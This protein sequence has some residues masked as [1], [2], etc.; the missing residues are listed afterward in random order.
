M[1]SS[2]QPNLLALNALITHDP[3]TTEPHYFRVLDHLKILSDQNRLFPDLRREVM[4]KF[5][6]FAADTSSKYSYP[7]S[8][9]SALANI[10]RK[11]A[12]LTQR[13][14]VLA[15]AEI[16]KLEA[17]LVMHV[18][19]P[20]ATRSRHRL[21]L[22]KL[23]DSRR[24]V[25]E[26]WILSL[27]PLSYNTIDREVRAW[28]DSPIDWDEVEYFRY[29]WEDF[30]YAPKAAKA[31]FDQF[32]P[33]VLEF[34]GIKLGDFTIIESNKPLALYQMTRSIREANSRANSLGL[35]CRF[36]A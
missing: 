1:S 5:P 8:P 17:E 27:H 4:P 29:D 31:F 9:P 36:R 21:R 15:F 13:F 32:K 26:N 18:D 25:W 2:S 22:Q 33:Q 19:W 14:S 11:Y 16:D 20:I 35:K 24:P 10:L 12:S 3:S 34:L 6:H 28:L 23:T 7:Y 30:F